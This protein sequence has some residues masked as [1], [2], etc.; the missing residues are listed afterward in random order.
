[1]LGHVYL[2]GSDTT[3]LSSTSPADDPSRRPCA[4]LLLASSHFMFLYVFFSL[5]KT[6]GQS[7]SFCAWQFV[8]VCAACLPVPTVD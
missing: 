8:R 5:V 6:L 3:L 7:A 2:D 1:M 4:L